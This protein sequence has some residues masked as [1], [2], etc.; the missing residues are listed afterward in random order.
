MLFADG[1]FQTPNCNDQTI[2]TFSDQHGIGDMLFNMTYSN[3]SD[4]FT[5]ISPVW[6]N[7]E[8][9]EVSSTLDVASID[10][11]GK[12]LNFSCTKDLGVE[13]PYERHW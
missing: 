6:Q 13:R 1:C 11:Q 7:L 4:H 12:K 9:R 10:L 5:T 3:P 2:T 8:F